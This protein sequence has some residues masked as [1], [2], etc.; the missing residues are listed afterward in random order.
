MKWG[1]NATHSEHIHNSPA[2]SHKSQSF[3]TLTYTHSPVIALVRRVYR[4]YYFSPVRNSLSYETVTDTHEP[5]TATQH[6]H[7]HTH[8]FSL[9]FALAF[10]DDFLVFYRIAVAIRLHNF[11]FYILT[12]ISAII[13][14]SLR[15]SVSIRCKIFY[16]FFRLVPRA[17]SV[18]VS[19]AVSSHFVLVFVFPMMIFSLHTIVMSSRVL[20]YLQI[21]IEKKENLMSKYGAEKKKMTKTKRKRNFTSN[22][23]C[24]SEIM[25]EHF[26]A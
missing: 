14:I 24:L 8:R 7:T 2:R 17:S 5:E 16:F 22:E 21:V 23:I 9:T 26:D 1:K 4:L 6:T 11:P 3:S 25:A 10:D 15:G 12:F 13:M 19:D 18:R 20:L